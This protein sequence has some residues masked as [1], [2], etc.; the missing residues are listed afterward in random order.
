MSRQRKRR[1]LEAVTTRPQKAPDP[2]APAAEN[3]GFPKEDK[4]TSET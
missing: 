4:E 2:Q 1:E 3:P